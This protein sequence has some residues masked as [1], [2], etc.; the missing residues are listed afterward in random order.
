MN[1]GTQTVADPVTR[2][3]N[4]SVLSLVLSNLVTIVIAVVQQWPVVKVM[5]IYWCQSVTIGFFTAL[6]MAALRKFTSQNVL[7]GVPGTWTQRGAVWF[8]LGH[9]GMFHLVYLGVLLVMMNMQHFPDENERWWGLPDI[10]G[11]VWMLACVGSFVVNH[12]YSFFHNVKEDLK[13]KPDL[14][15][16]MVV[17]YARIVPMHLC[18]AL[19]IAFMHNVFALVAFMLLKTCVDVKM[20]KVE[21]HIYRKSGA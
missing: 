9:Y 21:H 1:E 10:D 16:M 12:S 7:P 20:H 3:P 15:K 8:F 2:R 5:S 14:D 19:G 11:L 13:G 6:R 4:L 18:F 17:P